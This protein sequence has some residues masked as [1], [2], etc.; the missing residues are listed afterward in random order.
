[1]LNISS[2]VL[3]IALFLALLPVIQVA[4]GAPRYGTIK[5]NTLKKRLKVNRDKY[6]NEVVNFVGVYVDTIF[7]N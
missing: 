6:R 1:M 4:S 7:A 2:Q 5:E 3:F